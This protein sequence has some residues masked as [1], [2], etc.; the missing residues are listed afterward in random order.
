MASKSVDFAIRYSIS[1]T[2]P[3]V[4]RELVWAH[5][6]WM[7]PDWYRSKMLLVQL[8]RRGNH[9]DSRTDVQAAMPNLPAASTMTEPPSSV[10]TSRRSPAISQEL[11]GAAGSRFHGV[12]M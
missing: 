11:I 7:P 4:R 3:P 6:A 12:A 2:C 1:C 10:L 5:P 9:R 8:L